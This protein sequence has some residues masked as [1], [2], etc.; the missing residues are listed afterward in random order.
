WSS[1]VCSSDMSEHLN[2]LL[3]QYLDD[4]VTT[5]ERMRVEGHL[6]QCAEC[7][8]EL[9]GLRALVRRAGALD[10]RPPERDLWAGIVKRIG[11]ADTSDVAPLAPRRRQLVVS[12]VQLAAAASIL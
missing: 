6:A 5:L 1:D 10:D 8:A 2:E 12:W 7:R 3:S 9:E 11:S 4:E